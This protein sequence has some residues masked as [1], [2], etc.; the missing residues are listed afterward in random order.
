MKQ[1][2][3]AVLGLLLLTMP[4]IFTINYAT[5]GR[6]AFKTITGI[7]LV[8]AVMTY[9]QSPA[10]TK[11]NIAYHEASHAVVKTVLDNGGHDI[12]KA[13]LVKHFGFIHGGH[14]QPEAEFVDPLQL[15]SHI[16]VELASIAGIAQNRKL[17]RQQD[18]V[19][20]E[21]NLPLSRLTDR[22]N[23]IPTWGLGL[24]FHNDY[25]YSLVHTEMLVDD[26]DK[27]Q[28]K[29]KQLYQQAA[30]ITKEYES[31]ISR[32]AQALRTQGSLSGDEIEKLVYEERK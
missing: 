4:S 6:R 30:A 24:Q 25:Q 12:K 31:A 26:S 27:M 15:D 29:H 1:R 14:V 20:T 10:G 32:V 5:I 3:I 7:P 9:E 8:T 11:T 17:R 22:S 18:F 23:E 21:L 2:N 19:E 16:K 13:I 28:D